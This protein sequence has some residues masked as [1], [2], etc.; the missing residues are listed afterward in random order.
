[1]DY[2]TLENVEVE[3]GEDVEGRTSSSPKSSS[4]YY[5]SFRLLMSSN[6]EG[7]GVQ[8]TLVAENRYSCPQLPSAMNCTE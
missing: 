2:A 1:M 3:V 5:L 4:S 8:I 6:S 7:K